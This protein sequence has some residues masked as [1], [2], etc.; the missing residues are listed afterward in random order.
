MGIGWNESVKINNKK[1]GLFQVMKV[2]S[3]FS[4]FCREHMYKH[5]YCEHKSANKNNEE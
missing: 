3:F 4:Y 5:T 1:N 2:A